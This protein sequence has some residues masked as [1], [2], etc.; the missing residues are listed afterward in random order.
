[1]KRFFV[2]LLSS[3]MLLSLLLPFA[4]TIAA[5]A[6]DADSADNT[7]GIEGGNTVTNYAPNEKKTLEFSEE[8][9]ALS[10]ENVRITE[11][12]IRDFTRLIVCEAIPADIRGV[13]RETGGLNN[14]KNAAGV[15]DV[16]KYTPLIQAIINIAVVTSSMPNTGMPLPFFS[17][18]GTALIILLSAVGILLNISR[19]IEKV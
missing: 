5:G 6:V 17:Y 7:S 19:N 12:F 18:G 11:G 3:V 10:Y 8:L 14:I 2:C 13:S 4:L 1:M 16:D 9:T 15:F